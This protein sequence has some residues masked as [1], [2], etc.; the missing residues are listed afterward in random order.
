MKILVV[1]D[2]RT[3][4]KLE[5]SGFYVGK[6]EVTHCRVT[7]SAWMLI[8]SNEYDQVWLDHDMGDQKDVTWLTNMIERLAIEKEELLDIGEFIIHTSNP[9]ARMRMSQALSKF[10]NVRFVRAEDYL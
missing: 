8:T 2:E 5:G 6:N 3:L 9:V 10:Y 7:T 4:T 1:D